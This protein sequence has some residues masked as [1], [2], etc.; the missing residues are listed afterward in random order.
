MDRRLLSSGCAILLAAC[1]SGAMDVAPDPVF[2]IDA[3][4]GQVRNAR[5]SPDGTRLAWSQVVEGRSAIFVADADGQNGRAITSGVWD[6]NPI[7]S[8]DGAWIAYYSDEDADVYVVPSAGGD[9]RQLTSGPGADGAASWMPDGS[10]VVVERLEGGITRSLLVPLDGSP[11]R[12]LADM[13]GASA[14]GT[15]SPDG[16]QLVMQVTRGGQTTI[17]VRALPDGE[18]RQ[19]TTE[20]FE[21]PQTPFAWSPDGRSILYESRRTGTSDLWVIDATSGEQRQLT[22][23]VR[24]DYQGRWSPDGQRVLF[25]STRGGQQDLW[26]VPASGGPATRMTND[27][28]QENNPT[29]AP[30]GTRILFDVN[31]SR[32][33]LGVASLDG[34]APRTLA[35]W[36]GELLIDVQVSPDGQ[37]VLFTGGRGG[38]NDIFV[39]P[40]AGGEPTLL[41]GGPTEEGLPSWSPDGSQVLFASRRGG[42][43][44]LW[45]VAATGGEPVR[46]T[47]W[48]PSDEG[49]ARWSP[50]GTWIAFL[51]NR[52]EA[53]P[54]LW[55]MRGLDGEPKR[56]TSGLLVETFR[57]S[58]DGTELVIDGAVPGS[59][60]GLYAVPVTGGAPR[61]LVSGDVDVGSPDLSPDGQSV[62]FSRFTGGWGYIEVVPLGGGT[63][64][65]LTTR[66]DQV[67][68]TNPQWSPDGSVIAVEEYVLETNGQDLLLV[69][70]PGGEWRS[71]AS[72]P[73]TWLGIGDWTPDGSGLVV[74]GLEPRFRVV[75]LPMAATTP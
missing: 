25:V 63:P 39:I 12:P 11:P 54:Q 58:R 6:S 13:P 37:Q 26:V 57:W 75:A 72:T 19:L 15:P 10:G 30:D 64:R 34:T 3:G 59:G 74:V 48:A 1:G 68:Q 50:D 17:W 28:A 47:D 31:D 14:W 16:S 38:N 32:V 61:V 71:L 24:D 55:V 62:L 56:L 66:S 65:R 49:F 27:L 2:T 18:P 35:A 36:D 7:W 46:V 8:P 43:M 4:F 29:W 42:T 40:I 9:R 20:G 51:A 69:T 33:S 5:W 22:N 41:A 45:S 52:E 53:S 60:R 23:D 21:D 67:Y 70:W 73:G 44:D